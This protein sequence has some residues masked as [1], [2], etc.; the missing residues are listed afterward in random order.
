MLFKNIGKDI[1]KITRLVALI[2]LANQTFATDAIAFT[3]EGATLIDYLN[4]AQS[5]NPHLRAFHKRYQAAIAHIP[6]ASSLPD[7]K[8][9]ITSFVESIQTRTG[10]QE[11]AL[12]L[13]QKI[14]WFGKLNR[15]KDTWT[16]EAEALWYAY[17]TEQLAL[18]RRLSL[19]FFEYIYTKEATNLAQKNYDFLKNIEP[20]VQS[21]VEGGADLNALLRLK[22]EIGIINDELNSLEQRRIIQSAELAKL[23]ALPHTTILPWPIWEPINISD[24]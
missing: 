17:Q 5:A 6:Q 11:N 1:G 24:F 10:Q 2:S 15:S 4:Q 12:S 7:P 18:N 20:I 16:A 23:L 14:P 3:G 13:S 22:V 21:K 9:Q 8:L 19:A